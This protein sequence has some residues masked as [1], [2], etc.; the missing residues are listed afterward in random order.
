MCQISFS[1]GKSVRNLE[2]CLNQVTNL[3][4]TSKEIN[5]I[6]PAPRTHPFSGIFAK[7]AYTRQPQIDG[8]FC[9]IA[10]L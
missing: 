3:D 4:L 6:P 2:D 1:I 7:N 10:S 5:K 9:K 8:N